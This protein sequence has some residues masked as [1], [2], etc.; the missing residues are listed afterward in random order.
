MLLTPIAA[1]AGAIVPQGVWNGTIGTKAIVACF[2]KG[3]P[4][5]PYGSYYYVDYLKPIALTT[6]ET[7]SYWHEEDD[8]GQ[9]ELAV[10]LNGVVVGTSRNQKTGK[11]IPIKLAIVDGCKYLVMQ[12]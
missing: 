11:A 3:W 12:R 1:R 2:N 7:D 4:W 10:P 8:T 9:W 5:T 6:R